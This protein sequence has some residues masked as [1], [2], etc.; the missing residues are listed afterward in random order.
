MRGKTVKIMNFVG[1]QGCGDSFAACFVF[2]RTFFCKISW[3]CCLFVSNALP[4]FAETTRHKRFPY[5]A[6]AKDTDSAR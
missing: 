5:G 6:M 1:L 2:E 4:I 3:R